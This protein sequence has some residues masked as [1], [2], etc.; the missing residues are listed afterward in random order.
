MAVAEISKTETKLND[1]TTIPSITNYKSFELFDNKMLVHRYYNIG[2]GMFYEYGNG[3]FESGLKLIKPFE[4]FIRNYVPQGS[5][6]ANSLRGYLNLSYCPN[7]TQSF[8][9]VQDL[10][11]HLVVDC[12]IEEKIYKGTDKIKITFEK[13]LKEASAQARRVEE[14][15][16][17]TFATNNIE[18][19][20]EFFFK[21]SA[22]KS[23]T[24]DR[25]APVQ[26]NYLREKFL[27]GLL[28]LFLFYL[29]NV[30]LVG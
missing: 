27:E 26:W 4:N 25:L 19:A 30:S 6:P 16:D 8:H 15:S 13:K 21:G 10:E 20:K 23:R 9:T 18:A 24:I 29:P 22:L 7:C 11:E 3:K 1:M 17:I 28:Q 2:D 12:N 5:K 14:Q